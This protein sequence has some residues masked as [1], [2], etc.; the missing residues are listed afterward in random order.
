MEVFLHSFLK[1][2]LLYVFF[3]EQTKNE[4]FLK[5]LVKQP[6][7]DNFLDFVLMN[8]VHVITKKNVLKS[9]VI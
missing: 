9:R 6:R 5:Q 2:S 1:Q 3:V 4:D 8:R 7:G